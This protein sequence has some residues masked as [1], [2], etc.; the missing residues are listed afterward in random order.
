MTEEKKSSGK[1]LISGIIVIVLAGGAY[2]FLN[3]A[4]QQSAKTEA[5]IRS[6]EAAAGVPIRVAQ[7]GPSIGERK[8]IIPGEVK[9]FS[10]VTV[11]AKISGYLKKITV[12]KGDNVREGQL[13]ATIESPETD[14][15]YFAAEADAKNKRSIATRTETLHQKGVI[16][17]QETQQAT[18]D[19]ASAE[20]AL[21]SL[22]QLRSYETIRAPFSG[23][24][25]ARYADPGSLVQSAA[26]SQPGALPVVTISDV[27][28]LRIYIYLDQKDALYIREGDS[29]SI[30]LP[31]SPDINIPAT[32]TRYT[33]EIDSK[34]RTLLAEIDLD[35]K[36]NLILPGS[37][38][39]VALRIK[40]RPFLQIPSDALIMKGAQAF[41]ATVDTEGILHFKPIDIADNDGRVIQLASGLEAGETVALGV[42]DALKEGDKV[43]VIAP[44]QAK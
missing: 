16:S 1:V 11:Y 22:A 36:K 7:V 44:K 12:D 4:K 29:V 21:A 38:V 23:K 32:I 19:A 9:A 17:E 27:T 24:I 8:M 37:F 33:G 18:S 35:N 42:G 5:D 43:Q 15:N 25:T 20:A 2:L 13:I 26:S 31:E 28:K 34:T 39:Q 14:Q 41:V 30:R 3:N 10:S 40:A 6:K